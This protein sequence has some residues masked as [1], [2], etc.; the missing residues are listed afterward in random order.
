MAFMGLIPIYQPF[1]D[2]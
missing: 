2:R 1:M